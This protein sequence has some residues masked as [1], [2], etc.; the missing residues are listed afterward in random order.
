MLEE[1]CE[2]EGCYDVPTLL[3]APD[4]V[5]HGSYYRSDGTE[6]HIP[7][8]QAFAVTS[9][10]LFSRYWRKQGSPIWGVTWMYVTHEDFLNFLQLEL[11]DSA[12]CDNSNDADVSFPSKEANSM[13]DASMSTGDF[14]L[15]T[16]AKDDNCKVTCIDSTGSS[17]FGSSTV[18]T[19]I[20]TLTDQAMK[21][22]RGNYEKGV[23]KY[24]YQVPTLVGEKEVP[25]NKY[26]YQ[27]Q[28]PIRHPGEKEVPLLIPS[29]RPGEKEVPLLIPSSQTLSRDDRRHHHQ[30]E[31]GRS[32]L[33]EHGEQS[34]MPGCKQ[35]NRDEH[36]GPGE[37]LPSDLKRQCEHNGFL[38]RDSSSKLE[39][40]LERDKTYGSELELLKRE[41]ELELL[42]SALE[43]ELGQSFLTECNLNREKCNG[44]FSCQLK[45][46]HKPGEP[47]ASDQC[48]T[49]DEDLTIADD[50]DQTATHISTATLVVMTSPTHGEPTVPTDGEPP[51]GECAPAIN[52]DRDECILP[53]STT[54]TKQ[55]YA[56]VTASP[57]KVTTI[58]KVPTASPAKVLPTL[59]SLSSP[60]FSFTPSRPTIARSDG[61][62]LR[63]KIEPRDGNTCKPQQCTGSDEAQRPT[64]ST[65]LID[66]IAD[67][68]PPGNTAHNG[69]TLD[70]DNPSTHEVGMWNPVPRGWKK[71]DGKAGTVNSEAAGLKAPT[72]TPELTTMPYLATPTLY[73]ESVSATNIGQDN[74]NNTEA[75]TWNNGE[76]ANKTSHTQD[77]GECTQKGKALT[78]DPGE[79]TPDGDYLWIQLENR[80]D[81]LQPLTGFETIAMDKVASDM[82]TIAPSAKDAAL[83]F[84][85]D[86]AIT[87]ICPIKT[88]AYGW[89]VSTRFFGD[90]SSTE[91]LGKIK[92]ILCHCTFAIWLVALFCACFILNR[93]WSNQVGSDILLWLA[94]NQVTHISEGL[95]C[96]HVKDSQAF[97]DSDSGNDAQCNWTSTLPGN[98][99]STA[100]QIITHKAYHSG[101]I[102]LCTIYLLWMWASHKIASPSCVSALSMDVKATGD[103]SKLHLGLLLWCCPLL[104]MLGQLKDMLEDLLPSCGYQWFVSYGMILW[105]RCHRSCRFLS[106][107]IDKKHGSPGSDKYH[108][109][110]LKYG[111]EI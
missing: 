6:T 80:S 26:S 18:P 5:I 51:P 50:T 68:D 28:V 85:Q 69:P 21:K 46:E 84:E 13:S 56:E 111:P 44:A 48:S 22:G 25:K 27:Y 7:K 23:P 41:L 49:M 57:A 35:L 61:E 90:S 88:A 9:L 83:C 3:M 2:A 43:L 38:Q 55:S 102:M 105:R 52:E 54:G 37:T 67:D 14:D 29:S 76:Y 60:S 78:M 106:M 81:S 66:T 110:T 47:F 20:G 19:T 91:T 108:S 64:G 4:S 65:T 53:T 107:L 63:K 87:D 33:T 31:P 94:T 62:H 109:V 101:T 16:E 30:P 95:P 39:P 45:S 72:I 40:K 79:P 77:N 92:D 42:E 24:S 36:T 70:G 86:S 32:L 12:H 100:Y 98:V 8:S 71:W 1:M 97:A 74:L 99:M 10:R 89:R 75:H 34:F 15:S 103:P 96:D 82:P 104:Q 59:P 58:A 93:T 11:H 73:D 17:S